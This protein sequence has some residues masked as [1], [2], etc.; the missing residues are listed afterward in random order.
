MASNCFSKTKFE[1]AYCTSVQYLIDAGG[2]SDFAR[3][4]ISVAGSEKAMRIVSAAVLCFQ[5]PDP[6]PLDVLV[7]L[8]SKAGFI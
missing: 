7:G 1:T 2:F 5:C 4:Y 6:E 8:F 3:V